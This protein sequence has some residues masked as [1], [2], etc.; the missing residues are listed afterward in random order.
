[1]KWITHEATAVMAAVALHFPLPGVAAACVGAVLPDVLDQRL[2]RL[3]PTRRGRQ[4]IFNAI[5]RGTT[6]W[7][8]WWLLCCAAALVPSGLPALPPPLRPVLLGLGFGGLSH[9]L[10][11]MLTPAG[12]PLTPF[13]RKRKLSFKLCATGSLGEYVFLAGVLAAGWLFWGEELRRLWP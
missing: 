8:G 2:A 1:M 13:S 9:V 5:H 6:H 12:V 11:D 10:L 3:A 4:R 7:L